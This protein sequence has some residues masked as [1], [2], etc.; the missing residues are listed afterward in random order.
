MIPYQPR[1]TLT[2][3][4]AI[5]SNGTNLTSLNPKVGDIRIRETTESSIFLTAHVNFTNPTVYT[6]Q[7]PYVNINILN[8]GSIV[9]RASAKNVVVAN[10]NNTGI[11]VEVVW[12]PSGLGGKKGAAIARELLSQYVSGWN[13]TLTFQTHEG[14]FPLHPNL[15]KALSKFNV[16][17]PTPRLG[18]SRKDDS[19]DD[20]EDDEE[21][22]HKDAP[23]FIK[24]AVF[25]FFSSTASFT[26]LSPIQHTTI[27]ID[28]INATAFYNHTEDIGQILY[29]LP[30]AVPPSVDGSQTPRLPVDWSLGSVGYDAVRKA[31]GGVLKLDAK[32][33]IRVRVGRWREEIWFEGGGIGAR[34]SV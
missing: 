24:D 29:S 19:D 25:H 18:P 8:N 32:A 10:G 14:T 26:L 34:V 31:L 23:K 16:T 13:T 27:Y 28:T 6:A 4:S 12:D 9:G 21:D 3:L 20:G 1:R 15:G 2:R 11:A 33:R 17:I 30:F 5:L 22:P 7:V